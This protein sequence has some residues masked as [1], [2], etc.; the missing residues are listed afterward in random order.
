MAIQSQPSRIS[1]PFAGSG[2]R[3][4]IPAT[5]A[6]PSASQ[7]ASWASG[8]PP[9]CS[10]PISAGGCPVPR[11]DMNG[12]LNWLSQGFA[13]HQDGGVWAWSALADYDTQRMVLGSDGKLYWSVAQS[14]PGF[15]SGAVDPTA[16]DGTYWTSPAFKTMPLGDKSD[17]GATT[18]WV[19]DLAS[20][21]VYVAQNGL[22][23]NDGLSVQTPVPTVSQAISIAAS[24]ANSKYAYIIIDG[25]SYI[26]TSTIIIDSINCIFEI[27]GNVSI[28]VQQG[29]GLEIKNGANLSIQGAYYFTVSCPNISV[30]LRLLNSTLSLYCSRL[31]LPG[32]NTGIFAENSTVSSTG[33][34]DIEL[35]GSGGYGLVSD[36]SSFIVKS[37]IIIEGDSCSIGLWLRA[38]SSVKITSNLTIGNTT[39]SCSFSGLVV[40]ENSVLTCGGHCVVKT[41]T[42][43]KSAVEVYQGSVF[44]FNTAYLLLN[45]IGSIVTVAY[46]SYVIANGDITLD[47]NTTT[48][49]AIRCVECGV[50]MVNSDTV[51]LTGR[52]AFTSEFLLCDDNSIFYLPAIVSVTNL[53]TGVRCRAARGG[54]V[55]VLGGSTTKL[56]GNQS[57]SIDSTSFAYYG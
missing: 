27:G 45:G 30:N 50:F 2:T 11:N 10:L 35:S 25:G 55:K 19:K 51:T 12:V 34:I 13:Y 7:A 29:D 31:V 43:A 3:N 14:G 1:E 38:K 39:P 17:K 18:E 54:M 37:A 48:E 57:I 4:T 24:K 41:T 44:Y 52:G 56:P 47:C 22:A 20:A 23:T 46:C 8:F 33:L 28:T 40:S 5:N 21:P 49:I 26:E 32:G 15:A 42:S 36:S 6:S 9:E 53:A 16:D